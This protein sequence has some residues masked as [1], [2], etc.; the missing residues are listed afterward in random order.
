MRGW[1]ALIGVLGLSVVGCGDG[2]SDEPPPGHSIYVVP[3]TLDALADESFFDHPWPSDFRRGA[4]G[5]VRFAGF[6]N[7]RELPLL[8]QFTESMQ[9][10]LTGFSPAAGGFLRFT[11]ALNP[12]SLPAT[13]LDAMDA[14]SSVQLID[15]TPG[16][17]E[18]GE[19]QLIRVQ[20]APSPAL[21]YPDNTLTFLPVFGYPLKP[22]HRYA[23]VV[24][25]RIR[26]AAGGRVEAS[27]QLGEVLG[28]RPAG[29]ATQELRRALSEDV[30]AIEAA[31]VPR[32]TIVHLAVYSTNDP[33]AEVQALR[34]WVVKEYPAPTVQL[35]SWQ[36]RPKDNRPG[37]M[38]VYEGIYGP[39]PDFQKGSIPF[40]KYGD[41][42]ALAFDDSGT[43]E[44][45]REFDLRFT[46]AVP[47]PTKC[48]IPASGYPIVLYAHGTGGNYRSLL[49]AG[50]EAESL[51]KQCI[52]TM[53]IDQ[54]F[55][56]TRPGAAA[57]TPDLLFF[58]V[59]NL[60]A[61]RANGPQSA[62]DVVQQ[63]RLFTVS[64][65]TVPASV[66]YGGK[67]IRFDASKLGFFGH[68]QGG[69]NG[70]LYLAVD[71]SSL[72]A[73]LSGSASVIMI[74]LLEKTEPLNIAGLVKKVFLALAVEEEAELDEF[75]P[76]LNLAQTIVD[77][78]DPIHYVPYITRNP[79]SGFAPKSIL[80]TEGV[81]ADGSGDNFSTPRGIEA[82]AVAL[83]LPPQEPVI[84]PVYE[85]EFDAS[86]APVTIPKGGLSGN[87]A[88]GK[89]SGVLAQWEPAKTSDGHFVIYDIPAAMTQSA[90]FVRNF[91]DEPVGRVPAP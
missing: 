33:V 29:E 34:D 66:A 82:Q 19:R 26:T 41:G 20:L 14:N 50:D 72:G 45:Q 81:N 27:Q 62:I 80:M 10:L 11:T 59:Q 2:E 25:N 18:H 43:P 65:A 75:H 78:T 69:L 61:A 40:A 8:D 49:G 60:V 39:S 32:E 90:R 5:T 84:H 1:L 87:L 16:A 15:I 30:K 70:P 63:A 58:N 7:P 85:A 31:G 55:H 47:D 71:D 48:P 17:T 51:A 73:V 9:S 74:T 89:A 12:N 36:T 54:I 91:M 76:A 21:Y 44:L 35:S 86:L 57:G 22:E 67:E 88:D 52:A 79:R 13:P 46:L 28:A 24:T 23:L 53:G 38:E 83:G 42:G 56:G 37:V 4:D 64:K 6:P 3:A 68:S 77:P